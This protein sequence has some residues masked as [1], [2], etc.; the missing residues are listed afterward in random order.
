MTQFYQSQVTFSSF[1]E[2]LRQSIIDGNF[3]D[4]NIA[5]GLCLSKAEN[6]S[7][8]PCLGAQPGEDAKFKSS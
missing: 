6:A 1:M 2:L 4:I 5:E 8:E 3:G 7:T